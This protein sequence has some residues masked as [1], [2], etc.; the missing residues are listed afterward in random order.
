MYAKA[1]QCEPN[2]AFVPTQGERSKTIPIAKASRSRMLGGA[3]YDEEGRLR[4]L[5]ELAR[6]D[7]TNL[8]SSRGD[9]LVYE[10]DAKT[11]KSYVVDLKAAN[12]AGA[13]FVQSNRKLSHFVRDDLLEPADSVMTLSIYGNDIEIR[14]SALSSR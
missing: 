12:R 10:K 7:Y 14:S 9:R 8:F 2:A 5:P 11:G 4:L 13:V 6:S 3:F 1:D